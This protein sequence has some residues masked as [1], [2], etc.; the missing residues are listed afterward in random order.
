M[1]TTRA[2]SS[3]ALT[4]I[5]APVVGNFFSS[6]LEFL[7]EQC[8]LHITEKIPS[9]VK[10][11]SRPRIFLIR[12]NSSGVRPCCLMSSGVTAGS[13]VGIWLIIGKFTL[14]NPQ[15]RSNH[16]TKNFHQIATPWKR[17]AA[18]RTTNLGYQNEGGIMERKA[19]VALACVFIASSAFAQTTSKGTRYYRS[20]TAIT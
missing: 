16:S 11:G 15:V 14:T 13:A 6:L 8:S 19:I 20:T 5:L 7:Y 4:R 1:S 3:P 18:H 12:S 17:P 2:F 9:S 10:F